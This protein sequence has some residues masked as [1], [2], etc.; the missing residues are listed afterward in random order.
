MKSPEEILKNLVEYGYIT[1]DIIDSFEG[2][3]SYTTERACDLMHTL[4]CHLNHDMECLYY[5]QDWSG[6][7]RQYWLSLVVRMKAVFGCNDDKIISMA[8]RLARTLKDLKIE[9]KVILSMFYSEDPRL[10]IEEHED[11]QK[12]LPILDEP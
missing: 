2:R 4:V 8:S 9:E 7:D 12:A 11:K 6:K 10:I 5:E 3:P 1:E